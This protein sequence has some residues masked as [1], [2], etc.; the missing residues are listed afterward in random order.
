MRRS[1]KTVLLGSLIVLCAVV[2]LKGAALLVPSGTWAPT[3]NLAE[4]R[5]NSSAA[6][7]SDGR[8]LITGGDG[9]SG[10][11]AT[12]EFF[13]SDGS[14]SPAVPM[15][16][17]RS[18]HISVVLHDG[19]VLVAGGA[20]AGGGA[21]NGAEIYDPVANSWTNLS[22]GMV[23][24]RSG[25]TAVLLQDQRVFIAGG[26]NAGVVSVTTEIFDPIEST[27]SF[28]GALSSPRTQ[29]AMAVLA[30]GRVIII[31]GSNGTIPVPTSDIFD[32]AAGTVAP[33]PNLDVARSGHSATTLLNGQV[34]VA[35][36][37]KMVTNPDDSTSPVDLASAEVF[38]PVA[39]TFTT[40]AS[41]LSTARTGHL[42]FLL[43]RNNNVL[44]VGG[45]SAGMAVASSELFTPWQGTFSSTGSLSTARSN[46]ALSAM[47]QDGLLLV[48]GGK[49]ANGNSLG[50]TEVYGFATVK[51]DA[52]DYAPGSTVTI[53][54]SGWQQGET[55]TLT[56][57]ESP[58]VDTH[59]T[60][61]A[62]ADASGNIVNAQFS[63]D[64]HD[65]NIRF[66]LTAVGSVSG[67]Q[68]QTTFTDA[69]IGT[70]SVVVSPPGG[71]T[72]GGTA[73]YSVT[74]NFGGNT[75][76]CTT[77]L[78]VSGGLPTGAAGTWNGTSSTTA[79][80]TGASNNT[81]KTAT[82]AVT[83]TASGGSATPPGTY[84]F[85]VSASTG[86]GCN[87]SP[88]S[89][90]GTLIVD[91]TPPTVAIS[92]PSATLTAAGPITYTATYADTNFASSTLSA[93]NVTLNTTGTANATV[94][95]TGTGTT[96]T[97]TLSSITGNGTLGISIV[98]GTAS[99]TAGNLAPAAGPSATFT[100]DNTAPTISGVTPPAN[101]SYRAGQSLNF[102]VNYT[103]NVTVTGAPT[104]GLTIGVTPRSASY[105]SGSGSSA[106]VF[107]YTVQAGD[108]DS[109]GITSASPILLNG[110]TIKDGAANDASL[111]FTPPDTTGVLVD[112]TAP[113]AA[114][115]YSPT[116]PVKA[117]TS[118]TIT[119]TFS[120]PMADSPAVKIAISGANTLAP[121][122][123]TKTDNTHY[124]YIHT[125]GSGDGTT[126]VAL[127]VGTDLAGNVITSTPTSGATF[128][129]DNIAP[130]AAI[131]YS[132]TGPV[133]AGTSLTI[134]A[135]FSEPMAD[136]PVV[137][138]AI[139]GANTLAATNMTKTD[140]THYTYIHTVGSGDGTATV[141]LSAG[142][143][144]AGNVITSPPTSGATFAVDNTAPD[145]PTSPNLSP[146]DDSGISS[147][148]NI[149]NKTVNLTLTGTAEP[150]AKVELFEGA[151]SL[152]TAT[153]N[154]GSG[155]WSITAVGPFSEGD[156]FF[157]TKATDAAGNTSGASVPHKVTIDITKPTVTINQA[158]G[159]ADPAAVGPIHFTV[160]FSESAFNFTSAGVTLS[161]TAGA[162]TATVSGSGTTYNVTVS[163]MTTTG[164]VIASIAANVATDT[165]G[166][167]N[168]VSTST[169]NIVTYNPDNKPPIVTVSFGIP[170]GQNNWFIHSPVLGT[171]SANDTTTGN[172]NVTAITCSLDNSPMSVGSPT[173]I[174]TPSATGT[175]SVSGEGTHNVSCSA[176]DSAGNA[177][178]FTG[179]SAMPVV[180]KI[181]TQAPTGVTGAASRPAD[182]NGWFTSAVT[183]SFSG[184]DSTSGIASCISTN[185]S[186][187]DSAVASMSG[188]CTDQAGNSSSDV[189]FNF[190]FDSTPP[191]AVALSVTVGTLGTNGWYT[192]DV[193]VHTSGTESVSGPAN[194]TADQFLATET[195]GQLFNGSCTNDAGLSAGAA[196][197]TIKLDKTG[198]T[199][200]LVVAAGTLGDNGWYTSDVTVHAS[201]TDTISNPVSCGNDQVI[202]A[203]TTGTFVNGI[204][205][206]DAGLSTNATALT[207][208]LDKT[209]PLVT[210]A[211]TAGTAGTHSWYTSDV[212][213]HTSGTD[214]ISNIASCDADQHQTTETT[215]AVF[216][217]TCKNFAGLIGNAAPLTVKLDKTGPTAALAVT[218]GTLG[219]NAWYVSD[220]TIHASGDDTISNPTS[221]TADQLLNTD[222]TG[223]AFHGS[224]TNDAGLSTN[225]TDLSVK[226]DKTPPTVHIT[227]DR[228]ADH[229]SWYNHGLTFTN[230]GTDATS[231]I[232]SCT[233]P[234]AYTGP[235]T[236]SASVSA[237]CKDNAGNLGSG[238]FGFQFDATAPTNVAAAAD[239]IPDHN[240]WYNHMLTVTWTGMDTTSGI[241]SCTKTPFNGPDNTSASLSGTCTDIAG[242]TSGAVQFVFK[243]D[244]TPPNVTAAADR[245]T[246]HNGWYNHALTI[247]FSGTDTTSEID[248][249]DVA[250][251]YS[252]PDNASASVSGHCVD[253]AGNQGTGTLS[254][255]F[256]STPP[257]NVNGAPS[258]AADFNTWYNHAVAVQFTGMDAT[259][260]IDG[261][262]APLYSAPDTAAATSN[263]N[264]TDYAG[265]SS[266]MV[267]SSVFK[268]DAT[269]PTNIT[270]S[271][272]RVADHN[273]WY[274][275]ALTVTW[276]GTDATSGIGSCTSP[277]NYTG[278]DSATASMN[279][280]C[281]D[282]AGNT[283]A[284]PT[285]F[286]FKYDAT[287]PTIN[288]VA[289]ANG[290]SAIYTLNAG[291]ASNYTCND[292]VSGVATC[293]GPVLSGANFSTSVV[294]QNTFGVNATDQAGN[295]ASSTNTYY[296]H[297][298][299]GGLC[300]GDAGHQILQPINADGSSVFNGKSTSPAKFRVC[301]ANGVSIGTA[302]VVSNFSIYQIVAGTV[303]N[304][305]DEDVFSTTPDTAFRWDPTGMQWIFNINNKSYA[306]NKTYYFRIYL[307]DGTS[308]L[309]QYGLK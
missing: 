183:I 61:T 139:S 207:I 135:T 232:A 265:N 172:S 26:E 252:G 284:P 49:D 12:A 80:V 100:V 182:H 141:A 292:S 25:A 43:S 272:S 264:C 76:A 277:I 233:T 287:P 50:S 167:A 19:R 142:T 88:G 298:L 95:V 60:L 66:Y 198:P 199:A 29:H 150:S 180:V 140:S 16:I 79:T 7:L 171:V 27:F 217:G 192:S 186:G 240:G 297:Y 134:T 113:T 220:V 283:S 189:A 216:S 129:V 166:N 204:C 151:T 260:G 176:T 196:P 133:K 136:S 125:V 219:D 5:A 227:P 131:T 122:N 121:T 92:A 85:T 197:L 14:V 254:F 114:I 225:A 98:A 124:T 258:R 9:A 117:G 278:P 184:T 165:A 106:L 203:E 243:Y 147:S 99:D 193:T 242:N 285:S 130:T 263:G 160:V 162:T 126:T 18:K 65:L 247:S 175:L 271:A 93:G 32:P 294:G 101:G 35:G 179:S 236:A 308:I 146:S 97:V 118:L 132:P 239:R 224:C 231:G 157:T 169:D 75:T 235:D 268:Y 164:T 127:S 238:S 244:S 250:T 306:S 123:M 237:T 55:V 23:E 143:D 222:S 212:T 64:T 200:T 206:N 6:L 153:A 57:V 205:T 188:H 44:I 159:Q 170:D 270:G 68:A 115:T 202:S 223:T 302:G 104:L 245:G 303:M 174:G 187:P 149:T 15:N 251:P 58:L 53:T 286:V 163:G 89:G 8:I 34:L 296:I 148:D 78:S 248:S 301:D 47:Q 289:P 256:D 208:K 36:G 103:E 59:P 161:G 96:R 119:A 10:P 54:G 41:T 33:G 290:P 87:G 226:L 155:N 156:H 72:S 234:A 229:N 108:N 269:P 280:T 288:I 28:A 295:T 31:G 24:A 40:S 214:N 281:T 91:N 56:L 307:N 102:T 45:T 110:G 274:N 22:G 107:R 46:A 211:V 83:T 168:T 74:V 11:L 71:V 38:D 112:N 259:S 2:A 309:F 253:N 191:T 190:K 94:A 152:G 299:S 213:V 42:A 82:L 267:A 279:G 304:V 300:D 81:P 255:K 262:S 90:T 293:A 228:S 120:E 257:I 1:A 305:V 261:C 201:G 111:T 77:T 128:T 21:T 154:A 70:I 4:A 3:T 246:D 177:G 291:V 185:Y 249:C 230:P 210:T 266:A 195:A 13:N 273:G 138:I 86:T 221:C 105:L 51:T 194:C 137:K 69:N 276:T 39:G 241:D 109:D 178:A 62:V 215:G 275:H 67:F 145:P 20:V 116:G 282:N 218:A 30:D 84:N 173:G 17:A 63:P 158:V 37:T 73:N 144:L 48:A 181:D 52:S 209:P